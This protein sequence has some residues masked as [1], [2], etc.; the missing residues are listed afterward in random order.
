[1]VAGAFRAPDLTIHASVFESLG[2]LALSSKVDAE[3]AVPF[4]AL[5]HVVPVKCTIGASG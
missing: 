4:P 3:A 2:G 5:T 1:M